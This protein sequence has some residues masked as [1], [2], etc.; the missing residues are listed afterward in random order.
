MCPL[1][2]KSDRNF[3]RRNPKTA[4][5]TLPPSANLAVVR[6]RFDN[7]EMTAAA[8]RTFESP[9]RPSSGRHLGKRHLLYFR[10][11]ASA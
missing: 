2:P 9:L 11:S 3:H 1:P 6:L 5:P 8:L 7:L 10:L 4:V